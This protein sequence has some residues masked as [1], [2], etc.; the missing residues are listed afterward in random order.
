MH[1]EKRVP[2]GLVG[3]GAPVFLAGF[4]G[5]RLILHVP[6]GCDVGEIKRRALQEMGSKTSDVHVIEHELKKLAF[7]I[8]LE[9]WLESFDGQD[10]IHDPT[11][12]V[13]R[14]RLLL[15]TANACRQNFAD[16]ISSVV[17]DPNTRSL[18]VVLKTSDELV[19]RRT[20]IAEFVTSFWRD[21]LDA[22]STWRP[23]L[24]VVADL[25][26]R[27]LVAVDARSAALSQRIKRTI[28]RWRT[29]SAVALA[30]SMLA[31]P[32]AAKL[33]TSVSADFGVLSALSV[34]TDGQV[35]AN[36][37]S[38]AAKGLDEYFGDRNLII[39]QA[40]RRRDPPPPGQGPGGGGS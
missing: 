14:A 32:A 27:K 30:L 17:F 24:H 26:R 6:A 2:A 15:V 1:S 31:T 36:A 9:Q 20:Q 35:P 37:G 8:S 13:K 12:I 7:P 16:A 25:P 11:M 29:P 21:Q 40:P 38:F 22:G 3:R 23:S 39:A 28:H 5:S 19:K 33:G 10:V 4:A 18:F 34:F